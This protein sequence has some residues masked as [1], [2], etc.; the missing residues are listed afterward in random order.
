MMRIRYLSAEPMSDELVAEF[1]RSG[2]TLS[3]SETIDEF[4]GSI[5]ALDAVLYDYATH[6]PDELARVRRLRSERPTVPVIAVVDALDTA[7]DVPPATESLVDGWIEKAAV[8]TAPGH[9]V[10][11]LHRA[12][13]H[14][15]S[16]A[17]HTN[18]SPPT[19]VASETHR[20]S[21]E[22]QRLR[23]KNRRLESLGN[24][25]SHDLRNRLMVAWEYAV[26]AYETGNDD[27]LDRAETAI[28]RTKALIDEFV[29]LAHASRGISTLLAVSTHTAATDA[30]DS[31]SLD[32][33]TL[34]VGTDRLVRADPRLLRLLFEA[35]FDTVF[36]HA[37]SNVVVR[38]D[39]DD[40]GF[41]IEDGGSGIP[42]ER[43]EALRSGFDDPSSDADV[44]STIIR[45]VVTAHGWELALND[46]PDGGLRFEV[47]VDLRE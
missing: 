26:L 33:A 11:S 30:W 35:I 31:S 34:V 29:A 42:L 8:R 37:E 46:L 16:T 12:A 9:V 1:G 17:S 45:D 18:T 43:R 14:R 3:V 27:Y 13:E 40:S 5:D 10:S 20:T 19:V 38:I 41:S 15:H 47:V 2:A 32:S 6:G 44:E 28:D 23:T 21:G 22:R 36:E 39:A 7:A 4:G 24:A 25:L